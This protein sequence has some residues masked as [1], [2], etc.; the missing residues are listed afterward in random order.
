MHAEDI[1]VAQI[2]ATK[3]IALQVISESH[4]HLTPRTEA[5]EHNEA[6]FEL[7]SRIYREAWHAV[8]H[9]DI[10]EVPGSEQDEY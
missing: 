5:E 6:T 1:V 8:I 7:I 2:Q 3:E 9:P 4:L 10:T